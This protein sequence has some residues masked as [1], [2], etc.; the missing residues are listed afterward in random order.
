M[1]EAEC[2]SE[3]KRCVLTVAPWWDYKGS[4]V[5]ASERF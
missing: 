5:L 1:I 4:E 2:D 3:M